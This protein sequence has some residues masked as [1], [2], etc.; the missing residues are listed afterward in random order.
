MVLYIQLFAYQLVLEIEAHGYSI[1]GTGFRGPCIASHS[2][3]ALSILLIWGEGAT[4]R[5]LT[6][7]N[8]SFLNSK[9]QKKPKD[10]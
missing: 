6:T 10:N 5:Y 3:A 2:L 4:G 7:G 1:W 8:D 9:E